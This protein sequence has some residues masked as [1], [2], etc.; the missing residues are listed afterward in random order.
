[1]KDLYV[2]KDRDPESIK[3]FFMEEIWKDVPGYEGMYYVS[4]LG[5]VKNKRNVML[6]GRINSR[7][8]LRAALNKNGKTKEFRFHQLVAMAFLNHEPCGMERVVDHINGNKLD[9]RVENLRLVT[10]R[11]NCKPNKLTSKYTGVHFCKYVGK[12]ISKIFIN[13]KSKYLG[14]FED[15]YQAHLAYKKALENIL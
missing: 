2:S 3:A 7:G 13:G 9:N 11:E 4:N 14:K 6:T 5:K 10:Q 1:M 12:Y 15:E 8:Y